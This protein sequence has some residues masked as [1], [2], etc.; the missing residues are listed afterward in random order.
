M[1]TTISRTASAVLFFIVSVVGV[2]AQPARKEL[3]P[4]PLIRIIRYE[5]QRNWNDDLKMLLSGAE[6]MVRKRAA[7]AAGR[8][9]DARAIPTLADMVLMD[10]DKDVRQMAAF[11]LGEIELPGGAFALIQVLK[12]S[13]SELADANVRARRRVKGP[14]FARYGRARSGHRKTT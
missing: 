6:P 4:N 8:I 5:D 3:T 2:A 14:G 12:G 13:G 10:R 1:K 9:G 11:A 7:L